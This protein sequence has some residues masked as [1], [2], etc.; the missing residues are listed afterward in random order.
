VRKVHLLDFGSGNIGSLRRALR[1][2]GYFASVI[3]HEL[4]TTSPEVLFIPGVGSATYAMEK[5]RSSGLDKRLVERHRKGLP[6]VGICLGAQLFF[7]FL[8]EADRSGLGI[9]AGS[10]EPLETEVGFNNGWCHL[11]FDALKRL[12]LARGLRPNHS[13]YFNHQYRCAAPVD[14]DVVH[15]HE[16]DDVPALYVRGNLVGIQFHPEKSQRPGEVLL[17]NIMEDHYGL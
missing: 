3:D 16:L 4:I 5:L 2:V 8:C 10:V 17:R 6:I 7:E 12:G 13:F 15:L 14:L 1:Q 9:L 11:D